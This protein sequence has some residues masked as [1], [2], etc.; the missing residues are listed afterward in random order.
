MT[1][2][3]PHRLRSL[4][5]LI[6]RYLVVGLFA[7]LAAPLRAQEIIVGDGFEGFPM[8]DNKGGDSRFQKKGYG[9]LVLTDSTLAFYSCAGAS[10]KKHQGAYFTPEANIWSVPLTRIRSLSS[11]P[12][13]RG[14]SVGNRVL[15]G[16]LASDT[17]EELFAFTHDTETSAEAP[18]FKTPWHMSLAMEA[19]LRFRLRKFGIELLQ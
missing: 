11:N 5:K 16:A 15:F 14:A 10:C 2:T 17:Y 19:K 13:N 8:V 7:A 3:H 9:I 12:Q 6:L 1:L 18:V 4:H